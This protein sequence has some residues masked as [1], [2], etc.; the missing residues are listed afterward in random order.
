MV[1]GLTIAVVLLVA[2]WLVSWAGGDE[3]I[4]FILEFASLAAV[5]WAFCR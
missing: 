3:A 5:V 1:I 4:S 2:N